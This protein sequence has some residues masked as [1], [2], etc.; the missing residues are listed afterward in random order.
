MNV[1]GCAADYV[2]IGMA[3]EVESDDARR[4]SRWRSSGRSAPA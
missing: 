1:V 2:R 4:R 3:V